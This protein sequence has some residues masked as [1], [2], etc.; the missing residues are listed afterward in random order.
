MFL[1]HSGRVAALNMLKKPTKCESV[2]FFWTV[3]LGKS[4]R[5]TGKSIYCGKYHP[6]IRI[7]KPITKPHWGS[8][9]HPRLRGRLHRN[10]LQRQSG[11][12]EVPGVLHQVSS[13]GIPS[14][15]AECERMLCAECISCVLFTETRWWWRR[16]AWCLTLP[17]L[18]SQSWWRLVR[19]Y[20]RPRL[21]ECHPA[22]TQTRHILI[23]FIYSMHMKYMRLWSILLLCYVTMKQVPFFIVHFGH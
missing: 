7:F 23:F 21:S 9:P 20:R 14:D 19:L 6:C 18:V 12:K 3:L 10:P 4:I 11:G 13:C 5:Y 17:W 8:F 16:P 2:P 22:F 15:T 1:L